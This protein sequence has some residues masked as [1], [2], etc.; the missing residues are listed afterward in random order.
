M[1]MSELKVGWAQDREMWG[2]LLSEKR[3]THGST[4]A[5]TLIMIMMMMMMIY[6]IPEH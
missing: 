6:N 4:D 5:K 1:K 2:S 3:P